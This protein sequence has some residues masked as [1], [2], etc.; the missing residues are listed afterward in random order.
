MFSLP[1]WIKRSLTCASPWKSQLNNTFFVHSFFYFWYWIIAKLI[2]CMLCDWSHPCCRNQYQL[3]LF[4][5][6]IQIKKE[7]RAAE[8]IISSSSGLPT[9]FIICV[10]V[11]V[12][13]VWCLLL[14]GIFSEPGTTY[15]WLRTKQTK[16]LGNSHRTGFKSLDFQVNLHQKQARN[17]Q[18]EA[19]LDSLCKPH[20]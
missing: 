6:N 10:S 17:L 14:T 18:P 9:L 4:V 5:E 8:N 12:S 13:K 3:K 20:C 16:A 19:S 7:K 15:P 1:G 2:G 11:C